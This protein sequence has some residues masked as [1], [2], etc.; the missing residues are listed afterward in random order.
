MA[1]LCQGLGADDLST[2]AEVG[3][4]AR[5]GGGVASLSLQ[6]SAEETQRQSLASVAL[7]QPPSLRQSHHSDGSRNLYALNALFLFLD[8]N[9]DFEYSV[10]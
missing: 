2:G 1:S 4:H 3:K 6:S 5:L 10:F 8:Y 7:C 9:G